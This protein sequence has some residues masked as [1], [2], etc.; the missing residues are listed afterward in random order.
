MEVVKMLQALRAR[1]YL[2]AVVVL[3][4]AGAAV[5]VKL[6]SHS[7][8]TGAATVQIM[9]DSPQSAL[10][11]LKQDPLPL[12]SRATV[13]S[14]LMTSGV[15]LNDIAQTAGVPSSAVTA[16]GPYSGAGQ[17]LNVPTPSEARG[18]QIVA[19][20]A[21]YHL[22][23]VPDANIPLVTVSVEGP[24]PAAAGKLANA[25][26]PGVGSWLNGLQRAI[27]A[28]HRVTIR[29]LGDAQAGVV[30]SSSSTTLA[31]VT[32]AAVLL[33]GL[34]LIIIVEGSR[35]RRRASGT[36]EISSADLT[37]IA[38]SELENGRHYEWETNGTHT[39]LNSAGYEP[40][41]AAGERAWQQSD[42]LA[43]EE[44]SAAESEPGAGAT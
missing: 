24:S 42:S 10:A 40:L 18:A 14:Q 7:V 43:P 30:N 37:T 1:W 19:T 41:V 23:F 5:A 2:A 28:Y 21:P 29:Q 31:A 35:A 15:V 3:A 33:I 4:A 9:V 20:N 39:S 17:A 6:S 38:A 32:G 22:T 11:D 13:F 25:V 12:V 16:E 26:A 34:L 36:A 44:R 27:P 8:P